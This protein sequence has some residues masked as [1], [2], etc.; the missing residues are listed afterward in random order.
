MTGRERILAAFRGELPDYIPFAPNIYYWFYSR[1]ARRALPDEIAWADH[2]FD[3]LRY[4][5][6]DILARWDTQYATRE[7]F[8]AGAYSEEF[9]GETDFAD[10][11]V[12]A[13]NLYPPRKKVR[14]Q[15][16]VTPYGTLTC[17]WQLSGESV[18]DL[19]AE[20]WWKDWSEY[21]AVRFL[22]ENREFVFDAELFRNWVR[23]VGDDGLVMASVTFSP[24]KNFHWLCGA[25]QASLF[26]ADHPEEMKALA[27]IH[28]RKVLALIQQIVAVP[29]VEVLI[30]NDNLD[31]AFHPPRLF[32]EY[33]ES[34]YAQ[35]AEL[36]HRAGKILVV[37]ACGRNKALMPLVGAVRIDCLEGLTPPPNGDVLLPEAR[38]M[39]GYENF[40]VNGGMDAPRLEIR[41]HAER[42]LHTYTRELFAAMGDGRHFIYA[43]SCATPAGTP[44]E[45]LKY[46]RDAARAYGRPA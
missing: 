26:L 7:V 32:R 35:A 24:L 30:S 6:A 12:T 5:G 44:W 31:S 34:F 8:T 45:N 21:E 1:K 2:P 42:R 28:E 27:R 37:H 22:M 25:E 10:T 23:R 15:Q 17:R 9:E 46:L 3:V 36:A 40:T 11:V 43:S 38:R 29:E 13:F 39:A 4:L 19:V 16:L 33:C 41:E 14:R 20:P 18:A